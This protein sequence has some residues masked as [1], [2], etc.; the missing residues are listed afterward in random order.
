MFSPIV[1]G[2]CKVEMSSK[3]HTVCT[4][5][6]TLQPIKMN[7]NLILMSH[8]MSFLVNMKLHKI[9]WDINFVELPKVIPCILETKTITSFFFIPFSVLEL[10]Q[11][12]VFTGCQ[13]TGQRNGPFIGPLR[14]FSPVC[15]WRLAQGNTYTARLSYLGQISRAL[16]QKYVHFEEFNRFVNFNKHNSPNIWTIYTYPLSLTA[17]RPYFYVLSY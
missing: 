15:L 8:N 2:N 5:D 17:P 14:R 11:Q 13:L 1:Y 3:F 7:N 12:W 6:S 16:L 9:I 10:W 4:Y